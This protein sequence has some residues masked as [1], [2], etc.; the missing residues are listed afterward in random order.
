M[1]ARIISNLAFIVFTALLF[2]VS[3]SARL[4][5]FT[6]ETYGPYDDPM[7]EG[8]NCYGFGENCTITWVLGE[9][10]G[11]R[12]VG[13]TVYR[14]PL[15]SNDY[16]CVDIVF[17][18]GEQGDE[19]QEF[20]YNDRGL[21]ISDENKTYI[22]KYRLDVHIGGESQQYG[23]MLYRTGFPAASPTNDFLGPG[24]SPDG[25]IVELGVVSDREQTINCDVIEVGG[26]FSMGGFT[27]DIGPGEYVYRWEHNLDPGVYEVRIPMIGWG[28]QEFENKHKF[29]VD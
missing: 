23:P 27:R 9:G 3:C 4:S 17:L 12:E 20:S 24:V 13:F 25:R 8:F 10:F 29:T 19:K 5:E 11:G 2:S 18:T 22:Y 21:K 28:E 15:G 16:E 7:I 14:T 26:H 6:S 1:K